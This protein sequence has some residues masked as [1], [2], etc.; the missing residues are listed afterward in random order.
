MFCAVSAGS[1]VDA[2]ER[3]RASTA[4][5]PARLW[6]RPH[7]A[8]R[9]I[10]H[11]RHA[12]DERRRQPGPFAASRNSSRGLGGNRSAGAAGFT[13]LGTETASGAG[14]AAGG[15]S[16]FSNRSI[17]LAGSSVTPPWR[18]GA[19]DRLEL[20]AGPHGCGIRW[21]EPHPRRQRRESPQ[22]QQADKMA[23]AF[24]TNGYIIVTG[25]GPGVQADLPPAVDASVKLLVR[26]VQRSERDQSDAYRV[27]QERAPQERRDGKDGAAKLPPHDHA[28]QHRD[29]GAACVNPR[30][31]VGPSNR[32]AV[33]RARCCRPAPPHTALCRP[34]LQN[35]PAQTAFKVVG[36][37][38]G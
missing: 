15:T 12:F 34:E 17:E 24:D 35:V 38:S 29:Q 9:P 23:W 32:A 30:I 6:V 33:S 16:I 4:S 8:A 7:R 27:Q 1:A 19:R 21:R 18:K 14:A 22:R 11:F 31:H 13:A 3:Y 36:D 25:R 37:D 26:A 5:R 2:R 10:F 20:H 28:P